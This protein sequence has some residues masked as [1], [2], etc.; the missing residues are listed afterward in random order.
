MIH[1]L[2]PVELSGRGRTPRLGSDKARLVLASLAAELGHPVSLDT[3]VHRLWEDYPPNSPRENLHVYISR[4]RKALREIHPAAPATITQHA[5][6]YTLEADPDHVDWHRYRRL[7]YAATELAHGGDDIRAVAGIHA[8]EELWRGAPLAG[9]PGS[10]AASTRLAIEAQHRSVTASRIAMELRLERYA[11][12]A[13]ELASIV[14]QHPEDE[15]LIG[16]FMIAC[17]GSGRHAEALNVYQRA[18]QTLRETCGAD[19]GDELARIHQHI[20]R[21]APVRQLSRPEPA[22]EPV[23]TAN[24]PD[25]LPRHSPLIGR[26]REMRRLRGAAL[27]D[28]ERSPAIAVESI[29]GM[30]GV[31]KSCLALHAAQELQEHFP[32]G[33][34]YLD[35]H[36]HAAAQQPMSPRT[37]LG[38]LLRL[39]GVPAA[40]IPGDLAERAAMWRRHLAESRTLVILDDAA[41][42]EQIQPLLPAAPPSLA[43]ITS[44]SRMVG[45]GAVRSLALD[46]LPRDDAIALFRQLTSGADQEFGLPGADS[47]ED[48]EL[49]GIVHQCG[50][51]PLAIEI[52]ASRLTAHP[53]WTLREL[54]ERL[55]RAP[56]R[57]VEIRD[58]YREIASAFA[59]SYQTLAPQQRSAFRRLSLHTGPEFGLHAAAV[60]LGR[61][62]AETERVLED[63]LRG[64]LIQEPSPHRFRYHDLLGEYARTLCSVHREEESTEG[65]EGGEDGEDGGTYEASVA[66]LID[67]YVRTAGGCDR[68]LYPSRAPRTP[69]DVAAAESS[70]TPHALPAISPP[71]GIDTTEGARRWLATELLNLL[72]AHQYAR[73]HGMPERAALLADA[74]ADY[75]DAE[76][77]WAEAARMHEHAVQYW[78]STGDRRALCRSLLDLSS[79]LS[80]TARYQAADDA[81]RS[82]LE[83]ARE[84]GDVPSEIGALRILG[85]LHWH[86]GEN[87]MALTFNK[88]SLELCAVLQDPWTEARCRNN[89][90]IAQLYLGEH[91]LALR[92]FQGALNG[93]SASGDPRNF[94]KTLN[95]LGDLYRVT[96]AFNS[97][98]QAYEEALHLAENTGSRADVAITHANIAEL[99]LALGENGEGREKYTLALETFQKLGDKKNEA[100]A[101]CGLGR[102]AFSSGALDTALSHARRALGIAREIGATDEETQALRLTGQVE[103]ARGRS[104]LAVDHLTSALAVARC[105]GSSEE[106]S[107]TEEVLAEARRR[108]VRGTSS[109]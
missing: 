64:H 44:R 26:Q 97:A 68:L 25:N 38:A 91:E 106:V 48:A 60:L 61:P 39:A 72:S 89:T 54:S 58:G 52:A 59:M 42:P 14:E 67:F 109:E 82:A 5:H 57:L 31:G 6:T 102:A 19:V 56:G 85:I 22:A 104:G 12:L 71:P 37:A 10:W 47:A 92:N 2:G 13:G 74:L 4:I 23:R 93:F 70:R 43:L 83:L 81:A 18:R 50:Y 79:V 66:R 80:S 53:S 86:T 21:R 96:G 87:R 49:A 9:L 63:L 95:N 46:V 8:A 1:L 34:I 17:Y 88:R 40:R 29:S 55:A 75:L 20:L 99:L 105:T 27:A 16:Q 101:L 103:L 108:A 107:R 35:L 100:A 94:G 33:R 73:E 3:L 28:G 36:A 78:R 41:G 69:V 32:D 98:R 45:L 76:A 7:A 90:A 24:P 30:A 51:L 84:D 11:E 77:Q 62:V 65:G 15:T